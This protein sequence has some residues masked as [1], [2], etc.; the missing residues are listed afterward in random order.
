MSSVLLVALVVRVLVNVSL[1]AL[2]TQVFVPWSFNFRGRFRVGAR[3]LVAP[4]L[5]RSGWQFCH[6]GSPF[7]NQRAEGAAVQPGANSKVRKTTRLIATREFTASESSVRL[8][9]R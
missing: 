6:C 5:R 4:V 8:N 2:L 9:L 1:A 3:P 7:Q